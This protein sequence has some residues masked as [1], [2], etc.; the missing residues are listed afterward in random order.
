MFNTPLLAFRN[1]IPSRHS[2][3]LS[4]IITKSC[5]SCGCLGSNCINS[6]TLPI[7][8][9]AELLAVHARFVYVCIIACLPILRMR[10]SSNAI[11]VIVEQTLMTLQFSVT[12]FE[13]AVSFE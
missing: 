6:V 11:Y 3:P 5:S 7:I 12:F 1:S 9:T 8:F 10:T 13:R 4:A 2:M